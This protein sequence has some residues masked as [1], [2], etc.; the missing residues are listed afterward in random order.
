[1]TRRAAAPAAVIALLAPAAQPAA[2]APA[3][4]AARAVPPVRALATRPFYGG[5]PVLVDGRVLFARPRRDGSLAVLAAPAAGGAAEDLVRVPPRRSG[6]GIFGWDLAA[7]PAGLALRVTDSRTPARLW[8]G[9]FPGP[10][11]LVQDRTSPGAQTL[12]GANLWALPGGPLAL[13]P[14][15]RDG[16]RLRAM[17]RP[18]GAP[19]RRA[20]L[21]AG[22]DVRYL[23]VAGALAAVPV[24]ASREVVFVAPDSGAVVDRRP[25]GRWGSTAPIALGV[26]AGGD[27]ALTVEQP[28]SDLLGWSPQGAPE[29][30]IVATGE[31]FGKVRTANGRIAYTRPVRALDGER[32]VVLDVTGP[33]PRELFRGP[34]AAQVGGLDF[35]GTH[36]AWSSDGCQFVAEAVP[37]ASVP[38]VPRGPCVRTEASFTGSEDGSRDRFVRLGVRCLTAPGPRCR[39]DIRLYDVQQRI[40]RRAATVPVGRRRTLRVPLSRRV[41]SRLAGRPLGLEARVVDPG[42]RRRVAFYALY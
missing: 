21:P 34:P 41:R 22:A 42:G 9:P 12:D 10:L 27:V 16:T 32:V 26:S 11:S 7:S 20:P 23:A 19:A 8:A 13:E 1:M 14:T 36:V 17:L 38:K 24:P 3:H 2:A 5:S 30:R 18:L 29:P 33:E 4:E 15:D 40:D 37:A 25:L 31:G 39:I 6:L 35:D 28:G